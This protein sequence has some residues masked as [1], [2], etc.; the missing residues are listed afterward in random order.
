MLKTTYGY[1]L[2]KYFRCT[3]CYLECCRVGRGQQNAFPCKLLLKMSVKNPPSLSYA[4]LSVLFN[5]NRAKPFVRDRIDRHQTAFRQCSKQ[6][7]DRWRYRERNVILVLNALINARWLKFIADKKKKKT[8]SCL[9]S[10]LCET[11]WQDGS[12]GW[13][14]WKSVVQLLK[15]LMSGVLSDNW[16]LTSFQRLITQIKILC[17]NHF[18]IIMQKLICQFGLG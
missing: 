11:W 10:H 13:W 3:V 1:S 2:I 9:S 17:H 4:M 12:Q 15:T 6:A 5:K 7:I 18:L 8:G 16:G 14:I